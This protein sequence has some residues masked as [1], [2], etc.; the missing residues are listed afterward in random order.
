M[1]EG[2]RIDEGGFF[3]AIYFYNCESLMIVFF[4]E[5]IKFYLFFLKNISKLVV[6]KIYWFYFLEM[7]F[8]LALF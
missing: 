6:L 5:L 2:N 7:L 4:M 8:I 3:A 1:V